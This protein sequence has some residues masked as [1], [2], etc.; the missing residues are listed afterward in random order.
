MNESSTGFLDAVR[1]GDAAAVAAA[2]RAQPSLAATRDDQGV[3]AFLWASYA[4]QAAVRDLL[5]ATLSSLDVFEAIAAGDDARALD[6]LAAQPDLAHAW[7]GDGFTP[8]HFAGFFSRPVVAERLLVM[9]ADPAAVAK[10][11]TRVTPLHSAVAARCLDVVRLLL[12]RGAPA[13]AKQQ[14]GWTA[15]MSAGLHGD[16]ELAGLLLSHG[17][18]PGVRA[19]DGRSAAD[20]AAE[21]GHAALAERLRRLGQG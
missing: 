2:L 15:L 4:K 12:E 8:L 16:E 20:L 18:T 17:A 3:S 5:R 6:L 19:D 11:P 21:K 7:S 13:D 1:R 9:G 10:N 14:Q